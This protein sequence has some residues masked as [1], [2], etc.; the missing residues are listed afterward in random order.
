MARSCP[1]VCLCAPQKCTSFEAD[2]S[3]E[4][5][6]VERSKTPEKSENGPPSPAAQTCPQR[7]HSSI[8]TGM[9]QQSVQSCIPDRMNSFRHIAP[10]DCP[11]YASHLQHSTPFV[12]IRL[13]I[14]ML[15]GWEWRGIH[16]KLINDTVRRR[17]SSASWGAV[18]ISLTC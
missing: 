6:L 3:R 11:E 14:K 18:Q 8:I 2:T 12:I 7:V 17:L 5:A 4:G 1:S 16:T 15:S 13:D 9:Y 10:D